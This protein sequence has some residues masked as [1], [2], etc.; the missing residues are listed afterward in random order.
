MA[1]SLL[2]F[3]ALL[4]LCAF[5][6]GLRGVAGGTAPLLAVCATMLYFTLAGVLGLLVPAA[7]AFYMLAAGLCA[8]SLI[9]NR[10]KKLLQNLLCPGFLL[11][12]AM[13]LLALFYL[14]ARQP[15]FS[16]WDEFTF[17]GI[18]P[19]LVKQNGALYTTAETGWW[20][21]MTERPGMVLP[22]W[23]AQFLSGGFAEWPCIWSYSLLY[24]ACTGALLAPFAKKQWRI[25]IPLGVCGLVLPFFFNVFYHTVYLNQAYLSVYGDLPAGLLFGGALAVYLTARG[26]GHGALWAAL[27]LAALALV[28][29]NVFPLALAAAGVMAADTLFFGGS[30]AAKAPAAQPQGKK[31]LLALG[32]RLGP[33]AC[34]FAAPVAA[35]F[36]WQRHIAAVV[37]GGGPVTND[38]SLLQAAGQAFTQ[39]FGLAPRSAAFTAVGGNMLNTFLGRIPTG[40]GYA[41]GSN[42]ITMAGSGLVTCVLIVLLFVLAAVLCQTA[43]QRGRVLLSGGLM[44]AGFFA[45]NFMLLVVYAFYNHNKET[46]E[47]AS[48]GRYLSSYLAG[49]LMLGLLLL[50]MVAGARQLRAE[51]RYPKAGLARAGVLAMALFMALRTAVL[52]RPGYSVLDYP[53]SAFAQQQAWKEKAQAVLEEVPKDGRVFFVCQ[54]DNGR[55]YGAYHYYLLPV[56]LDYSYTGGIVPT[57]AAG[58][59]GVSLDELEAYLSQNGCGYILVDALSDDFVAF[60]ATLFTDELAAPLAGGTVLYQRQADGRYAPLRALG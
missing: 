37:Q 13:G 16:E 6:A 11:F 21:A 4:C 35:G 32:R 14:A 1:S 53:S 60:Y 41:E 47:I 12:F 56:I 28:K 59:D 43:R 19:K 5:F 46:G 58:G 18:A 22:G 2:Y 45:Y 42:N 34:F 17:W 26:R 23:A 51:R 49:W 27:P 7:W 39:L 30:V 40:D 20:W 54:T 50:A 10:P 15:L 57:P 44:L 3:L 52:V 29:E 48:F 55:A 24:F 33:A 36:V 9:K 25:W 31:R 8:F 38:V